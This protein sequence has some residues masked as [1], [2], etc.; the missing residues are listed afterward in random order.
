[1][2]KFKSKFFLSILLLL[3]TVKQKKLHRFIFAMTL[4]NLS[5]LE[6]IIGTHIP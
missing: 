5:V 2:T 1:M 3:Y 6:I 4:S